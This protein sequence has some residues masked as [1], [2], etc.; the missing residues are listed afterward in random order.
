MKI[1][2][3]TPVFNCSTYICEAI[4]SVL[5]QNCANFEHIVVDG[6]STDG[7]QEILKKYQ[8]LKWI[9]EPDNGQSDAMNK[10][11]KMSTGD[12]IVYLNADDYFLP[13]AF[14]SVL[15]YFEKG[16]NFVVG[17]ILVTRYDGTQWINDAMVSREAMLRH[18]KRQSFCVNPVGYFYR[19]EV[20]E[21]VS[22]FN[23]A[24]HFAM[25]LEFLLEC[26]IKY[27]FTKMDNAPIL[28]VFRNIRNT[29]TENIKA[30]MSDYWSEENFSFINRF[31]P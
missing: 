5:L 6:G 9:S 28:G 7:T 3:I 22:G 20:Q 31:L 27:P 26:S 2:V 21:S 29:K 17:K 24:N 19:R 8:H 15:P 4:E 30:G 10:G 11:F 18:W 14:S 12:I 1:S 25:D 16:A 23:V 13:G